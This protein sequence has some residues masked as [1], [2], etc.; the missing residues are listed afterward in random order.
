MLLGRFLIKYMQKTV[1][2]ENVLTNPETP[3][4]SEDENFI[5]Y[6]Y[7]NGTKEYVD[8]LKIIEVKGTFSITVKKRNG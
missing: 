8:K 6:S 3:V 4:R 1:K 2:K 5:Y 7:S